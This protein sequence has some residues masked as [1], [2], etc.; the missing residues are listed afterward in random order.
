[1]TGWCVPPLSEAGR[2]MYSGLYQKSLVGREGGIFHTLDQYTS[3][4]RSYN[5][6]IHLRD[7][8][9]RSCVTDGRS[10]DIRV[11]SFDIATISVT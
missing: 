7:T 11:S 1:V 10:C 5:D 4:S 3:R 8:D 2:W 9:G 6:K